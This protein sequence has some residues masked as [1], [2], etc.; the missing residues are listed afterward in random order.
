MGMTAIQFRKTERVEQ[1]QSKV[2]GSSGNTSKGASVT[3]SGGA[4]G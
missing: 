2:T 1:P 3:L 4:R